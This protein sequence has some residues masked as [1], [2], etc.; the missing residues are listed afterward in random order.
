[1]LLMELESFLKY[2]RFFE[3]NYKF[4]DYRGYSYIKTA[5]TILC[6]CLLFCQARFVR[7]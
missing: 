1:L 3:V 4:E 7:S 6:I 5:K 2:S